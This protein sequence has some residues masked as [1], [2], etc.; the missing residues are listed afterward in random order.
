M[1]QAYRAL[2]LLCHKFLR[3]CSIARA[4]H[5][6]RDRRGTMAA[7]N[8]RCRVAIECAMWRSVLSGGA[9]GSITFGKVRCL[10]V[11]GGTRF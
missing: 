5:G 2:V 11:R 3:D 8:L 10:E 9:A 4:R 1:F 6:Q 7:V